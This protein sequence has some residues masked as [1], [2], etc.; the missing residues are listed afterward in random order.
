MSGVILYGYGEPAEGKTVVG[1][2]RGS[3]MQEDPDSDAREG[4]KE[5]A[6]GYRQPVVSTWR[7]ARWMDQKPSVQEL[8]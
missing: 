3:G 1:A 6:A 2:M 4:A 8:I 5:A 7:A